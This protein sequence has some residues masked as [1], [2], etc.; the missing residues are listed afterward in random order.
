MAN[1]NNLPL[2]DEERKN[3]AHRRY[4]WAIVAINVILAGFIIWEIIELFTNI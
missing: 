1:D 4:Y 2:S 3:I